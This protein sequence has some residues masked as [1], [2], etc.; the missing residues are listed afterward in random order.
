MYRLTRWLVCGSVILCAGIFASNAAAAAQFPQCPAVGA[1][2]GCQ[3]L[4]T[5]G[6][7]GTSLATDPSQPS[8][9]NNLAAT[10]E[11]HTATDALVGVQNDTSTALTSLNITGPIT[12]EFDGDGICDNA[13]GVIPKGCQTPSGSTACGPA[14]GPCSFPPPAGEPAGYTDFG[15]PHGTPAWPNGDVQNG[16]EGPTSWFSNVAPS[17]NDGGTVNFSPAVPPGRSTYF[18]LEAAPKDLPVTTY[19]T[20]TQSAAG[21]SGAILYLPRGVRV[22]SAGQ[23][24]GGS[25]HIA[26][27]VTFRL[28]RDQ[29]CAGSSVYAG[30][31]NVASGPVASN[32]VRMG[33]AGT[34]YWQATYGGDGT[35]APSVSGC[36]N[37][38]VVIPKSGSVGLPSN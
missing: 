20:T 24:V 33:A 4:I 3:Y 11:T 6:P 13:S 7:L 35:N 32:P 10:G 2:T 9:A 36:G 8:Y 26:G 19:L 31:S 21:V 22:R 23:L 12:F 18:S 15:A 1:D 34:Y 5:V 30:T 29:T 38:A 28:Y 27:Q 17:P 37:Q 16:Y 25:G 14:N